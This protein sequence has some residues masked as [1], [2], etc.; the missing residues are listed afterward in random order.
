MEDKKRLLLFF[1]FFFFS[2]FFFALNTPPMESAVDEVRSF[3]CTDGSGQDAWWAVTTGW[4]HVSTEYYKATIMTWSFFKNWLEPD[5]TTPSQR[6][7][8]AC[9]TSSNTNWTALSCQ[10]HGPLPALWM[11]TMLMQKIN[12][13]MICLNNI[14]KGFQTQMQN[15]SVLWINSLLERDWIETEDF[16][17]EEHNDT[18]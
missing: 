12:F 11:H 8:N 13:Q 3:R 18:I 10:H 9:K 14:K 6:E 17:L 2:F 16:Y 1:N 15:C 4:C 7:M 5:W